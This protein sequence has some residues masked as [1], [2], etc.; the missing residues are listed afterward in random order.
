MITKLLRRDRL[1]PGFFFSGLLILIGIV[2]RPAGDWIMIQEEGNYNLLFLP[3]FLIIIAFF[4]VFQ[5]VRKKGLVFLAIPSAFY[6][7]IMFYYVILGTMS[8]YL[9]VLSSFPLDYSESLK[10]SYLL[11]ALAIVGWIV[12]YVIASP[13]F[14]NNLTVTSKLV[15]SKT[16]LLLATRIW[17]ILGIGLM[18]YFLFG[19][20]GGIPSLNG[21][22]GNVDTG[23]M[24]IVGNE[25]RFISVAAFNANAIG[26]W[27]G[28]VYLATYGLNLFILGLFIFGILLFVGWG[29]RLYF[30][31]PLMVAGLMYIR[32]RKPKILPVVIFTLVCFVVFVLFGWWRNRQ[33]FQINQ[34]SLT[35]T[36][37]YINLSPEYRE[38]LGVIKYQDILSGYFPPANFFRAIYLPMLPTS[39]WKMLSDVNKNEIFTNSSAW[40]IA[41]VVKNSTFTGIRPGVLAELLMAFG[42]AGVFVGPLLLGILFSFFDKIITN[43]LSNSVYLALT[44][45]ASVLFSLLMVGQIE[46][47]FIRLWYGIY[48]FVLIVIFSAK[49]KIAVEERRY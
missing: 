26:L 44:Y 28:G 10:E 4:V 36:L 40:I 2:I 45:Y 37:A 49:R 15:W 1:W 16:R 32:N 13:L 47:S 8:Q 34:Y 19:V 39:L 25:G 22:I 33:I 20:V 12:G 17:L 23:L 38:F 29:P 48:A 9:R 30:S 24:N 46:S 3:L 7:A 5:N 35:P 43:S 42:P 14:H 18:S 41:N 11:S 31:I 21:I 6:L 27:L